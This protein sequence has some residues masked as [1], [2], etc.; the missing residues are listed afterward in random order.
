MIEK[1]KWCKSRGIQKFLFN[2]E[3]CSFFYLSQAIYDNK[4]VLSVI[5]I[6][7]YYGLINEN[8]SS[9]EVG[10]AL[11][12]LF[13]V[14]KYICL[15][16]NLKKKKAEDYKYQVEFY[17]TPKELPAEETMLGIYKAVED[18][19]YEALLI[20]RDIETGGIL[21]RLTFQEFMDS[22]YSQTIKYAVIRMCEGKDCKTSKKT[23]KRLTIDKG[24]WA[25]G[26]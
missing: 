23:S 15:A 22:D 17:C 16:K 2:R 8:K 3:N 25:Y 5:L 18:N 26:E 1:E 11:K 9:K 19:V 7:N 21:Q 13:G 20:Q 6:N 10:R 24:I 14:D 4:G 12:R